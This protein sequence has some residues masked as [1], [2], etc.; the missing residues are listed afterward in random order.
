[1]EAL[2]PRLINSAFRV[3]QTLNRGATHQSDGVRAYMEKGKFCWRQ[4]PRAS[5]EAS[6]SSFT[7][8]RGYWVARANEGQGNRPA[9]ES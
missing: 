5:Q 7:A 6:R 1:M 4:M 2:A 3:A 8:D 9:V